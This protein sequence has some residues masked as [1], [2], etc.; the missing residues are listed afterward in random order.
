MR[1]W[2]KVLPFFVVCWISTRYGERY[3]NLPKFGTYT[4]PYKGVLI[5]IE[6]KEAE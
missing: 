2:L 5:R 4:S 3:S 1:L 6:P